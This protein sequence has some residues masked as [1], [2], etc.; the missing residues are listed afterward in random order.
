MGACAQR[1]VKQGKELKTLQFSRGVHTS[2]A[3]VPYTLH[4]VIIV[5]RKVASLLTLH[6]IECSLF[7]HSRSRL[8]SLHVYNVFHIEIISLYVHCDV[9]WSELE[10]SALCF[11]VVKSNKVW[12][13]LTAVSPYFSLIGYFCNK[14]C[15]SKLP[16]W[17]SFS[18]IR[19]QSALIWRI[20]TELFQS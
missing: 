10:A 18:L 2:K 6:N 12:A 7:C 17:K 20:T 5:Q 1:W 13:A 15:F 3:Q 19:Y 11:K 8:L 14:P 16:W 9:L 4:F